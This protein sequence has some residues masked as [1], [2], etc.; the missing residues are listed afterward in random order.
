MSAAVEKLHNSN[1]QIDTIFVIDD[2]P[3]SRKVA[4]RGLQ[5]AYNVVLFSNVTDALEACL[6]YQPDCILLD[7]MMPGVDGIEMLQIIKQHNLL[8]NT[9]VIC[10]SGNNSQEQRDLTKREGSSGFLSK[11]LRVKSL[12]KEI[13][14]FI[15]LMNDSKTSKNERISF[16]IFFNELEK[17][18]FLEKIFQTEQENAPKTLILSWQR[19][20]D[21]FSNHPYLKRSLELDQ[22]IFFEIKP[23]LI[24]KF[25]YLQDLT[26]LATDISELI[27]HSTRDYQ[28]LFDEPALLFPMGQREKAITQAY[29][30]AQI[31]HPHFSKVSYFSVREYDEHERHF[32]N[33]L[34]QIFTGAK[35]GN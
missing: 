3:L 30:F 35:G 19:G 28:L 1:A 17:F 13:K 31:I 6:E 2:D 7:I 26:C 20:E 34:C 33:K 8:C 9:P 18:K 23:N 32:M 10:M 4:E 21:F 5:E 22:L 11:P 12:S 24:S 14:T 25:P 29:N 15:L 16:H 27:G